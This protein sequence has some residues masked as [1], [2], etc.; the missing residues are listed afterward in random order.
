MDQL[1]HLLTARASPFGL[2]HQPAL[3]STLGL[4]SLPHPRLNEVPVTPQRL[5]DSRLLHLA[6]ES[7]E[8]VLERAINHD[9]GHA[10]AFGQ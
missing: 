9:K 6:V 3:S 10:F 8:C 1:I 5:Q 7:F 4:K 2:G